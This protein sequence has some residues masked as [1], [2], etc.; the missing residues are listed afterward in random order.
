[1][2][3]FLRSKSK[4]I[5][6]YVLFSSIIL[7]FVF[8]RFY[9]GDT[10]IGGFAAQVNHHTI[11][12][13]E[14]KQAY[15]Q[16]NQYYSS[17]F[18]GRMNNDAQQQA[19][20]QNA[21]LERLIT[22]ELLA[23]GAEKAGLIVSDTEVKD[24]IVGIPAFQK[25][26]RFNRDNYQAFLNYRGISA[27]Q[28]ESQLRREL[29]SQKAQKFFEKTLSPTDAEV[30]REFKDR[31]TKLN[32]SFAS[33]D[34]NAVAESMKVDDAMAQKLLSAADGTKRAEEYYNSHRDL[35]KNDLEVRARHILI[36]IEKG[37]AASEA[38][39]KK[40]IDEIAEKAKKDDF[41][42]L[43]AQYSED[44]GSKAKNGDLGFFSKG[45]MVPE[46]EKVAFELPIGKV[47]APVKS[48]FGYHLIKVEERK[49][50][51]DQKFEDV[52]LDAAKRVLKQ[53]LVKAKVEEL[54]TAVTNGDVAK[55][56]ELLKGFSA[57]WEDTGL[58]SASAEEIPKI[59]H[60]ESLGAS[61]AGLTSA[62]PMVKSLTSIGTKYY[63]VKLKERKDAPAPKDTE[64]KA[65]RTQ[66]AQSQS[67]GTLSA[68]AERM[69]QT[70]KITRNRMLNQM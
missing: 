27:S 24:M 4:S 60:N 44:P 52:K 55:T 29:L 11:S 66:L 62:N 25:D 61:L 48:S 45:R 57:K 59:G 6:V 51:R 67:Y 46:F 7:V 70:A 23:E 26:G 41:G 22:Q 34:Q 10:S 17:L 36:G 50:A 40:K 28:F 20:I 38:Q 21:T 13:N 9:S 30:Q 63:V 42:K 3:T 12:L 37:N 65:I 68:W 1:M 58:F 35:Y 33:L 8:F 47:S 15:E 19:M 16:M 53:D 39:A 69:K 43:A 49:E 31:E 2:F 56:E 5:V 18:G 64:L 32:L 54:K 14:Y